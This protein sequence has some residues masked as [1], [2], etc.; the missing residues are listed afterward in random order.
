MMGVRGF[1]SCS[2]RLSR[3]VRESMPLF[4]LAGNVGSATLSRAWYGACACHGGLPR[5]SLSTSLRNDLATQGFAVQRGFLSAPTVASLLEDAMALEG[6]SREAGVGSKQSR[7]RDAGV[8]RCRTLALHPPPLS[9][10]G[11]P[12]VRLGLSRLTHELCA[13]LSGESQTTSE[14]PLDPLET[15]LGYIYYPIGGCY[16]AHVDVPAAEGGWTRSPFGGQLERRREVSVIIYLNSGWEP[17]WGGALRIHDNDGPQRDVAP[18]GGTLVLMRSDRMHEVLPTSRPRHA[19]VGWLRATRRAGRH[20]A[21]VA[22]LVSD[23][24][25]NDEPSPVVE[26]DA[27]AP[28][29]EDASSSPRCM[30]SVDDASLDLNEFRYW[31]D[32]RLA[33]DDDSVAPAAP[34]PGLCRGGA[35]GGPGQRP[36]PK[37]AQASTRR[38]SGRGVRWLA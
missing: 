8:R 16:E 31:R 4:D 24:G 2:Q 27:L 12:D 3:V 23:G 33:R 38:R 19:V 25:T 26:D 21:P 17:A 13:E 7:R 20:A 35:V 37:R 18:E 28:P 1:L 6:M 9:T 10:A 30:E 32:R 36:L 11:R 29:G 34:R 5:S 14:P 22:V 15:E